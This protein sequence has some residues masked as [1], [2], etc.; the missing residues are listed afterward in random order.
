MP[1]Y[2]NDITRKIKNHSDNDFQKTK[3]SS[4]ETKPKDISEATANILNLIVKEKREFSSLK[5]KAHK[6]NKNI[7]KEGIN[8]V[9]KAWENKK[10]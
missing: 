9:S 10:K 2:K 8:K 3:D 1:D 4:L 5:G 6:I 7:H